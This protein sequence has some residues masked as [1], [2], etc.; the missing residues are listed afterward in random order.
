[1]GFTGKG[2][3]DLMKRR[4]SLCVPARAGLGLL[5]TA[6]VLAAAGCANNQRV[7]L[8]GTVTYQGQPLQAAIVKIYGPGDHSSMAYIRDGSFHI[9]DVTPGEIQVTV[10]SDPSGGKRTALPK[11]YADRNTSGLSFQITP[12]SRDLKINLE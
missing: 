11:K 8:H 10:E 2:N 9:T 7:T 12:G 6:L 1:M 4:A 3:A 5:M